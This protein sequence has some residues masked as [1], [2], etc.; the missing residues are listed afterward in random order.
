MSTGKQVRGQSG[1]GASRRTGVAPRVNVLAVLAH[2]R[3]QILDP[4][5]QDGN[6]GR[7]E[8]RAMQWEGKGGSEW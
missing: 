7:E 1:H 6:C 5:R 3:R 2:V 4:V 8:R